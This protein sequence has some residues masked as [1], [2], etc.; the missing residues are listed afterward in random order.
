MATTINHGKN[1]RVQFLWN[2]R[3]ISRSTSLDVIVS[4]IV[5]CL[6]TFFDNADDGND[7]DNAGSDVDDANDAK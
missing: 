4:Q 1:I 6:Q 7:A 2:T 3:N 5:G